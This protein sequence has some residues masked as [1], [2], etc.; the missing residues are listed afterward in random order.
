MFQPNP[1]RALMIGLGGGTFNRVFGQAYPQASLTTVE[2]DRKVQ[3]LATEHMGFTTSARNNVTIADGR[4][5]IRR[6]KGREVRLADRRRLQG[7]HRPAAPQDGRVLQGSRAL[8]SL[9]AAS[10]PST[11]RIPPS[12][13]TSTS[14][15][16][17]QRS[18]R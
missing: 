15:H 10:Q 12:F 3:E 2:L 16:S 17:K 13:S 7:Q 11:F 8:S 4:M 1:S 6:N 18:R 5:I 9:R 14:R